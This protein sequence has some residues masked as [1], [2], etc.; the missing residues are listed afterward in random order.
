MSAETER[1]LTSEIDGLVLKHEPIEIDPPEREMPQ[2]LETLTGGRP[3]QTEAFTGGHAAQTE[4]FTGGQAERTEAPTVGGQSEQLQ[5]GARTKGDAVIAPLLRPRSPKREPSA[6]EEDGLNQRLD[7]GFKEPQGVNKDTPLY[8]AEQTADITR[9][10]NE[11]GTP[12]CTESL[13]DASICGGSHPVELH[14]EQIAVATRK[15]IA[16]LQVEAPHLLPPHLRPPPPSEE[17]R[18]AAK[19]EKKRRQKAAKASNAAAAPGNTTS[20]ATDLGQQTNNGF[21]AVTAPAAVVSGVEDKKRWC[22]RCGC[23]HKRSAPCI[24]KCAQCGKFHR[25]NCRRCPCFNLF[26]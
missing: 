7:T 16:L 25:G 6:D 26:E 14:D 15:A 4:A 18:K 19:K 1:E 21:T 3:Q 12:S 11:N 10:W 22:H 24:P 9:W 2:R 13:P 8:T 20:Q 23:V 17:E 5:T